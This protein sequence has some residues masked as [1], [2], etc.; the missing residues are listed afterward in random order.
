MTYLHRSTAM[1]RYPVHIGL[2]GGHMH[3][4]GI[5]SSQGGGFGS[6]HVGRHTVPHSTHT[7]PPSQSGL[8]RP[9]ATQSSVKL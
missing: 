7:L 5:Q 6:S 8:L 2:A 9:P 3:E 4:L 1:H